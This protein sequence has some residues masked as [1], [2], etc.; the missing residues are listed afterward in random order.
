MKINMK[1]RYRETDK[2]EPYIIRYY[3]RNKRLLKKHLK[4]VL[5]NIS[6]TLK[7]YD[8]D[9]TIS[10]IDN[11]AYYYSIDI[12]LKDKNSNLSG[13]L[14]YCEKSDFNKHSKKTQHILKGFRHDIIINSLDIKPNF[15]NE[16]NIFMLVIRDFSKEENLLE[17]S[18]IEHPLIQD[19][20]NKYEV[21][22]NYL[23]K[24]NIYVFSPDNVFC[25]LKN[26]YISDDIYWN[27][28]YT[29]NSNN[30][31]AKFDF[32]NVRKIHLNDEKTFILSMIEAHVINI[33]Q[34]I[35]EVLTW[36]INDIFAM[37][38]LIGY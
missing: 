20:K 26:F 27:S 8:W 10:V 23:I 17:F 6:N 31:V 12:E 9:I 15:K 7:I 34:D 2:I 1:Y 24:E 18:A 5:T 36:D 29:F 13:V 14:M 30:S 4:L 35:E 33:N 25:G 11:G 16:N 22:Y 32:S 21:L 28:A 38:K 37:S 19:F 3:E